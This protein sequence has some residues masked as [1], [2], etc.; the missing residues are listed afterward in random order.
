MYLGSLLGRVKEVDGGA[1]GDRMGPYIQHS[2]ETETGNNPIVLI[3]ENVGGGQ[4]GIVDDTVRFTASQN[5]R[6]SVPLGANQ[7]DT[8]VEE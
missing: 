8:A 6:S 5:I 4:E 3:S 2:A 7:V 1:F